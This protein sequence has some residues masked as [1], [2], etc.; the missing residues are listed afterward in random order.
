[1]R[2]YYLKVRIIDTVTLDSDTILWGGSYD[3]LM[4]INLRDLDT[5]DFHNPKIDRINIGSKKGK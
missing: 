2:G 1:M 5:I 3:S 4:A